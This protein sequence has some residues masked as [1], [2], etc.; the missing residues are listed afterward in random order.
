MAQ[1]SLARNPLSLFGVWLTTISAFA[2]IAYYVVE[3]L[4]FLGS[5]YSGLFGFV[6]VPAVFV[7]GLVLIPVGVWRE[8][9]RRH[10]GEQPWRWPTIELG[11]SR[12]RQVVMAVTVLTLVNL[13]IVTVAGF[14][15]VHYMETDQFC[16]QVCHVP[17]RPEF[18]AHRQPPHASVECVRCHVSPG[19]AGLVRAK[20]NGT[21]QAYELLTGTYPRPIPS[22]PAKNIPVAAET[23]WHCHSPGFPEREI[24]RPGYEFDN[25]EANTDKSSPI[26]IF[27][28]KAHWHARPDIRIEYV[29]TD[30]KRENI[31]YMKVTDAGKVTEYFGQN[32]TAPPTGTTRRMDCLDCHSRPGH[33]FFPSPERAVDSALGTGRVNRA[34]PFVRREMLAALKADYPNEGAADQAIQQRL[35][36][37]YQTKGPALAGDAARAVTVAQELYRT[38]IFTAMK[39]TWGTY[40]NQLGHSDV[41]GCFRCHDDE[42]KSRDGRVIKQDCDL[43]H[44]DQEPASQK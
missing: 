15:A 20:L 38:N 16:G 31:P 21:R 36:T 14:G 3:S 37:F 17:M 12:T 5:P 39:V 33:A 13:V 32:V 29:T 23:C 28:A 42:H 30:A 6:F 4:G 41:N 34:L 11:S 8:A 43:C 10:H 7:V 35:A 22:S 1:P 40:Q 27:T 26:V 24:L 9:R 2:F 25:D 44:R 18:T 19:A